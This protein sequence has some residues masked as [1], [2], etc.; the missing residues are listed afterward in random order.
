MR[1]I[2][3][4]MN[5]SVDGFMAAPG[6]ELNWHF[7]SWTTEMAEALCEQLSKADTILLGGNTY[8]AM[9]AYWP[10]RSNNFNFP[11]D[12]IAFAEM[13][14]SYSKIV[15]SKTLKSLHWYNSKLIKKNVNDELLKLKQ[16]PGKD[17]IIFGSGMLVASLMAPGLI[18]EY[19]LWVHPVILS[20]GTPLFAALPGTLNMKLNKIRQFRSGVIVMDYCTGG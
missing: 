17:M 6:G 9:A 4:S 8:K 19:I 14:N 1:K 3:V 16:L 7:E 20:G 10:G 5:V 13:M 18:D 11:R 15:V 12:D 2:V